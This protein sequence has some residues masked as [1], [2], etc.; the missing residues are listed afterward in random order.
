MQQDFVLPQL[1]FY[2]LELNNKQKCQKM[3]LL[4]ILFI[5]YQ[6]SCDR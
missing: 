1:S 5:K 2:C 4:F 6:I 3:S